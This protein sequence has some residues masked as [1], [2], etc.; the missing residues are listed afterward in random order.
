MAALD[1]IGHGLT[2]PPTQYRLY[3][4]GDVAWQ[5]SMPQCGPTVIT[6]LNKLSSNTVTTTSSVHFCA[7]V[8]KFINNCYHYCC[9]YS[10]LASCSV[11]GQRRD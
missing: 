6:C 7:V 3:G 2:S 11:K 8:Y 1:W 9:H 10:Q 5:Q 4:M